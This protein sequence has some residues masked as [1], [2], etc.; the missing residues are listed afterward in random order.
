MTILQFI[1]QIMLICGLVVASVVALFSVPWYVLGSV[2]VVTLFIIWRLMPA[3]DGYSSETVIQA[4]NTQHNPSLSGASSA[5][6]DSPLVQQEPELLYRGAPY[7]NSA[8]N[9]PASPSATLS[10]RG[11]NYSVEGRSL[12]QAITSSD[13]PS[14]A[15]EL[16]YRGAKVPPK[17]AS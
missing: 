6:Q 15:P 5:Q 12:D 8:A 13:K 9:Q 10:Y 14:T 1:C 4:I 17:S 16:K 7:S 11:A 2:L 3:A